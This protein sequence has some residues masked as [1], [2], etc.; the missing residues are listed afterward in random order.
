MSLDRRLVKLEAVRG[1]RPDREADA[2]FARLAAWLDRL[3]ALKAA[4]DVEAQ[5]ETDAL[6]G[7]R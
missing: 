4:G 6:P 5:R 3:A 7:R 1:S 2:A